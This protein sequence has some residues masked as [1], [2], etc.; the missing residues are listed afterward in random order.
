MAGRTRRVH[1][2]QQHVGVTIDP[3]AGHALGIAFIVL[4]H[5]A[6][7]PRNWL[8]VNS[9]PIV[10]VFSVIVFQISDKLTDLYM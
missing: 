4:A 6:L 5:V 9:M 2:D 3:Q 1:L 10:R 7:R 8:F